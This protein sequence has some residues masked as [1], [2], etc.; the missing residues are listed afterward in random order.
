MKTSF[1]KTLLISMLVVA[2]DVHAANAVGWDAP[3]QAF[4]YFVVAVAFLASI[5]VLAL[6]RTA[7]TT[8]AWSLADALSEE[9]QVTLMAPP[10][11]GGAPQPVMDAN[12]KPI[13]VTEM[14]ASS[15]RLIALTGMVVILIMFVG[16]GVF[17]LHSF[18]KTGQMP[19]S[20]DD[21]LKFL[22]GGMTLFA[23]YVVNKFASSFESLSP[24]KQ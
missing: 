2:A 3:G 16:F 24:K 5:I 8:P 4:V 19:A 11:G 17:T 22:A 14:R 23:P 21:V 12:N 1:D 15:S 20:V 10:A 9:V 18:G 7:L 13:M 6:I